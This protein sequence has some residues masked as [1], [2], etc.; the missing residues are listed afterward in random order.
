MISFT[1]KITYGVTVL[2]MLHCFPACAA[3]LMDVYE[4]SLQNDPT[5]QAA[6]A[7][8][9]ANRENL[10]QAIANLLPN[11]SAVAN[12][13]A[14]KQN[15]SGSAALVNA[16]TG[17]NGQN[18][19]FGWQTFNQHGYT[20][21]LTETLFNFAQWMQVSQASATAKQA[22]ATLVAAN[23]DLII[24]V[25]QAYFNVLFAQDNLRFTEAELKATS[26]QLDQANERYSVG[27][28]AITT[29]D[30]AKASYDAVVAQQIAAQNTL[31]N[32]QEAL[33]QLTGR[34]Y[35]TLDGFKHK[36]PLLTPQPANV[37]QWVTTS[38]QRNAT[39]LAQRYAVEAQRALIKENIAG[40]L[41][42]VNAVGTYG[43]S[44]GQFTTFKTNINNKGETIGVQ[45][46]IPL[47][48][49][50][51]VLSQTRQAEDN[52][53]AAAAN[54]ENIHRQ[55]EIATRQDFNNILSGISK[56]RADEQAVIS[57]ESSLAS[58][59]ES[60]KVG[61]RTILDVLQELQNLYQA[62]TNFAQDQYSYLLNTLQLKQ[63]A[64]TLNPGDLAGINTWLNRSTSA[65]ITR[66][67]TAK[68]SVISHKKSH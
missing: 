10:P 28:D 38:E 16:T 6:V 55:A 45:V 27:L 68:Q 19:T 58:T 61:T 46:S 44:Y 15:V 60:Y 62:K 57:A 52:Y 24:R 36:V 5:Y 29:V 12:S 53:A 9:L 2:T 67:T 40:H 21:T 26:Q 49:G 34:T 51:K 1:R 14:S 65:D 13:T 64:G 30:N 56:V 32:N 47:F 63:A 42:Q 11:I 37:G 4:Q 48:A 18:N 22:D 23:Q 33:L 41:P 31:R 20:V 54:M 43:E 7:T 66:E 59:E 50:G 25:A 8:R 39:L 35:S 17:P 3:N